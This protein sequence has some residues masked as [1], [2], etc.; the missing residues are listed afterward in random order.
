MTFLNL[1]KDIFRYFYSKGLLV[2]SVQNNFLT[3]KYVLK[4]SMINNNIKYIFGDVPF[5]W[6]GTVAKE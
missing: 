6:C 5:N 1:N 3:L 4:F 2:Y